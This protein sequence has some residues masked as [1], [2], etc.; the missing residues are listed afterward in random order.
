M[1]HEAL[2]KLCGL[3]QLVGDAFEAHCTF[4]RV[5]DLERL[6]QP[7]STQ[8]SALISTLCRAQVKP[9]VCKVSQF[10]HAEELTHGLTHGSLDGMR[11]VEGE[12]GTRDNRDSGQQGSQ[13]RG[14]LHS[15]Y[16]QVVF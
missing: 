10:L 4:A 5:F 6:E 1:L 14:V 3:P 2:H 16:T 9:L 7:C 11:K 15:R 8:W 13:R 12:T